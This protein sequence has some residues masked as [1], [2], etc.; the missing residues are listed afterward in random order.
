MKLLG[1]EKTEQGRTWLYSE[2]CL[3]YRVGWDHICRAASLIYEY[4]SDPEIIVGDAYGE[5]EVTVKESR[6]ITG[7]EESG[8]LSI[9]GS[10]EIIRVPVLITF[11]NQTDHVRVYVL[12]ANDEFAE[13]DYKNFNL[14]M[15][16]F[17][18]SVELAMYR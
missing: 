15:C 16:Q 9:R 6:E 3:T 4:T 13:A 18:D 14:S 1:V 11:Y 8:W 17:M 12:S 5:T 7:L 2:W 10:S